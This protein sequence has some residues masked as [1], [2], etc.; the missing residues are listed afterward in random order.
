MKN[1]YEV[2]GIS[3]NATDDEVKNAYRAKARELYEQNAASEDFSANGENAMTEINDAYDA[4]IRERMG[5]GGQSVGGNYPDIRQ[6]IQQRRYT[7]AEELLD[8][9][10]SASRGAEWYYLKGTV[11]YQKG[12]LEE[13][14]R[15]FSQASYLDPNNAEYRQAVERSNVNRSGGY[16]TTDPQSTGCNSGCG[17]C[18]NLCSTLICMDCCCE[19][20]G[21]NLTSCCGCR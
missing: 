8:G 11:L 15:H 13:A 19:C 18:S 17:D 6:L 9:I 20:M 14:Q 3:P 16:R 2:L 7:Q 12:W 4:I 5:A 1:P 21:G 10:P